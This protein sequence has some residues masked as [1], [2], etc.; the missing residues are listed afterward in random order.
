MAIYFEGSI[1]KTVIFGAPFLF[2]IVILIPISVI[3]VIKSC[4]FG[5]DWES[6]GHELHCKKCT[7]ILYPEDDD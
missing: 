5:H 4:T 2:I 1:E 3:K 7:A 6:Q